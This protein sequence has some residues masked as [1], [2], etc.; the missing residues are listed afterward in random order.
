MSTRRL[1]RRW[2]LLA[3]MMPLP[4]LV[5]KLVFGRGL[6]LPA[7]K[8][9]IP[10]TSDD[11]L[12]AALQDAGAG[13]HIVL[14]DGVY[15]RELL[16]S[17]GGAAAAPLVIRSARPLGARLTG[18]IELGAPDIWLAGLDVSGGG[19]V[20]D[21]RV[22]VSHCR[23]SET[24]GIALTVARGKDISVEYCAFQACSGRGLSIAPKG[25]PGS[26]VAPHIHYN[27]FSGFRGEAGE[28]A[29]EA[30]QIGQFGGDAALAVQAVVDSN[31]F[32]D[33]N[34]DSEIISVKSSENIISNNTFLDSKARPTNRFGNRN[35]WLGNWVEN[36]HGMWVYGA[37]HE[38]AGNRVLGSRDGMCLMAGNTEPDTVRVARSDD[39]GKKGKDLRPHC[40]GVSVV[41]NSCDRLVV[42]R[43]VEKAKPPF[44]LPAAGTRI[45][46][47]AGPIELELQVDTRVDESTRANPQTARKLNAAEV[48][49]G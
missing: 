14:A 46:G 27:L 38:L 4:L 11:E 42:G 9:E 28:N 20:G 22:R 25:K 30:V 3:G 49:P 23:F 21:D 43:V 1:T 47:H 17:S 39:S 6:D 31:L 19:I 24:S 48:G 45:A 26:V 10:V 5:P 2:A 40:Q 35:R 18:R 8:R 41:G 16:V 32:V 29:H 15:G 13:D 36:C 12:S 34:V 44:T 33:V 37:D 7:Q